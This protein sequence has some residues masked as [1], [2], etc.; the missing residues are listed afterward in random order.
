MRIL[1]LHNKYKI[2]GGEDSVV[3]AELAVLSKNHN[4]QL[5]SFDNSAIDGGLK[6]LM[7]GI[8]TIFNIKSF[9]KVVKNIK[10]FKPDVIHVHNFFP[11]ASPS[12]IWAA[13]YCSVPIVMT[14]HNYRLICS[15]GLL[16]SKGSI[17]EKCIKKV[18]PYYGIKKRCY[19]NSFLNSTLLGLMLLVHRLLGTWSI[20]SKFVFL[21]DFA[22]DKFKESYF[23]LSNKQIFVKPNFIPVPKIENHS[24]QGALFIGR[25]SEEKGVY[26]LVK[27]WKHDK[28]LTV[29]GNGPLLLK[30]KS[31]NLSNV[32]FVGMKSKEQVYQLMASTEFLV[33][34]SLWYEGFPMVIVE[35]Y[36]HGTPVICSGIGGMKAVVEDY[37]TGIHFENG[38][39][40]DLQEKIEWA[41]ANRGKL[42]QMGA[43][44]LQTFL[45]NYTDTIAEQN[46]LA[47][48][49]SCISIRN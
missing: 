24:R 47:L 41:F 42:K 44:A 38:N 2:R 9:F 31:L 3:S 16:L 10:S 8:G 19:Q 39:Y 49:K 45:K 20:V 22:V 29:V 32:C 4:V 27:D 7:V 1:V 5:V 30:L 26:E 25:I 48:Y 17:C 40:E 6:K 21:T 35:A 11:I 28:L 46:L 34:P 13:K 18:M 23:P 12:V 37:K 33:V 36:A 43:Y 15:N 14:I